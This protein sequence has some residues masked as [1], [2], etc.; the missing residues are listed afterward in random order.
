MDRVFLLDRSGSMNSCREDT[1]QGFNS[2][3]ESQ[4]SLGGT[5]TLC[6]FDNEVTILYTKIPIE[7]VVP[8]S[9]DTY[10]PSGGT[11]L[12]DAMGHILKMKLEKA[13]VIIL[14][15]G[16]ENSSTKYT[17][18]HIKDLVESKKNWDFMY[19][20]AN[21]DAV[22][23]AKRIGIRRSLNYDATQTSVAFATLSSQYSGI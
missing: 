7:N 6:L 9:E 4:K 1:I 12:Y 18:L 16:D 11:A 2:F 13:L 8:L 21:Q 3:V 19:L 15:D 5:M 14:T 10:V 20:G 22:L 17:S 23:S